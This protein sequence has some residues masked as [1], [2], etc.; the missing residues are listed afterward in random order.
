M[1]FRSSLFLFV[2][3]FAF[4]PALAS[5][6]QIVLQP[7]DSGSKDVLVTQDADF[8]FNTAA[9]GFGNF[10]AVGANAG[11]HGN[12]KSLIG[13]DLSGYSASLP[14]A[15]V[16]NATLQ[17]YAVSASSSVGFGV[18][19]DAADPLTYSVQG[20]AGTWS[21]DTITWSTANALPLTSNF[22]LSGGSQD[23]VNDWIPFD[24]T[25]A[26]KSWLDGTS[27]NDGLLISG[28]APVTIGGHEAIGSFYS[29]LGGD[30]VSPD[31]N[32]LY[33][34]PR[35]VITTVPEP[36]TLALAGGLFGSMA[37]V[38]FHKRRGAKGNTTSGSEENL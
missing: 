8:N 30:A 10:L 1:S 25:A 18:D 31:A 24:V 22:T 15:N 4:L 27:P 21:A 23:H 2:S 29:A 32:G 17:L 13:F 19:P 14:S 36:G 35:L 28:A 26:V 20:L 33:Y 5:A 3:G 37:L 34:E 16:V 38:Y 12:T 6:G 11:S 9:S 7:S